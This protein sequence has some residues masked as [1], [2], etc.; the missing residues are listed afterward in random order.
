MELWGFELRVSVEP[1]IGVVWMWTAQPITAGMAPM[2]HERGCL[3]GGD[4]G[5]QSP[6]FAALSMVSLSPTPSR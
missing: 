4:G 6:L 5:E 3:Q 1:V 2:G